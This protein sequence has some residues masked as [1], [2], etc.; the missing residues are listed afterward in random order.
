MYSTDTVTGSCK[1]S[2]ASEDH[3]TSKSTGSQR[4]GR[5]SATEQQHSTS[6]L[7]LW[8]GIQ[9]AWLVWAS[10]CDFIHSAKNALPW[11]HP[12]DKAHRGKLFGLSHSYEKGQASGQH[13]SISKLVFHSPAVRFLVVWDVKNLAC[14]ETQF[15]PWSDPLEKGMAITPEPL[16]WRIQQGQRSLLVTVHGVANSWHRIGWEWTEHIYTHKL[17]TCLSWVY[18]PERSLKWFNQLH[19]NKAPFYSKNLSLWQMKKCF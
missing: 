18:F 11:E 1:L 17:S 6:K 4:V 9:P 19:L 2:E 16:L 12:V 5:I 7:H 15:D 3:C 13:C 10:Q 8:A 14:T